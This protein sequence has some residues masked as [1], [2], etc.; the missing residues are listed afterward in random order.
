[1]K[2]TECIIACHGCWAYDIETETCSIQEE[3]D[4][5]PITWGLI[6]WTLGDVDNALREGWHLRDIAIDITASVGGQLP[7]HRR[8]VVLMF[9]E[10]QV[11]WMESILDRLQ[12]P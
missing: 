9:L 1:M 3:A 12:G 10:Q 5:K 6:G 4:R 2:H 11:M 7:P 8:D